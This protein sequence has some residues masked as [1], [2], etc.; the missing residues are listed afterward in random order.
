[1]AK[2]YFYY[3]LHRSDWSR[4]RRGLVLSHVVEATL[5]WVDFKVG[6]AG[7]ERVRR[8]GR[9]NV[10]AYAVAERWHEGHTMDPS[11]LRSA[12]EVT[13]NPHKHETFV[14]K[15]TGAPCYGAAAAFLM[16]DRRVFVVGGRE[17]E[18]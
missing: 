7:R 2:H 4:K 10:H 5:T 18:G 11:E 16:S 1:M 8:E 6:A 13:Y 12:R 14:F 17:V 9:K 15:D 3:N